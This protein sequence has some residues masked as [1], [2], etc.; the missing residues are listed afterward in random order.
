M[1]IPYRD[2]DYGFDYGSAKVTRIASNEDLGWVVVE[3]E[4]PKTRVQV[5]AT[6]T[7]QVRLYVDGQEL[8]LTDR[9]GRGSVT[10]PT[11]EGV[12]PT[13]RTRGHTSAPTR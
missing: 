1:K 4:T 10:R 12:T 2:T 11:V 9:T 3:I 8:T 6:K 5:Y 13:A 7:G